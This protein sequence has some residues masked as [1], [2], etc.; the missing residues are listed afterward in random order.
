MP[1]GI[2]GG[3]L[4][5]IAKLDNRFGILALGII[6]FAALGVTQFFFSHVGTTRGEG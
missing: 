1:L 3:K 5:D 2:L 6:G 4:H